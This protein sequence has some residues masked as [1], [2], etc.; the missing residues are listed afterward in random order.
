MTRIVLVRQIWPLMFA[1]ALG[2]CAS[3]PASARAQVDLSIEVSMDP[4]LFVPGGHNLFS[5]TIRNAGPDDAGT[6]FPDE[7]PVRVFGTSIVFPPTQDVPI[8]IRGVRSGDCWL[9]IYSEP[10]QNGNWVVQYSYFFDPIPAGTSHTCTSD[11]YFSTLAPQRTLVNWRVTSSN[12]TDID[13]SNNRVDF[14]FMAEPPA[15]VP[16]GSALASV[17]LVVGMWLAGAWARRR[18]GEGR[19]E[20]VPNDARMRE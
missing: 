7:K 17:T 13:P 11:V 16:A 19:Y 4:P 20:R 18:G 15:P 12:D 5:V 8:D 10:L 1:V 6:I 2:P 9:D 3:A 14:T